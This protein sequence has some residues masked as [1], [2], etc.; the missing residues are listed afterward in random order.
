MDGSAERGYSGASLHA[1]LN[2]LRSRWL[3]DQELDIVG[4]VT[5]FVRLLLEK[6]G[7]MAPWS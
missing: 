1:V 5:D 3:L 2:G 4:P 6:N 7:E